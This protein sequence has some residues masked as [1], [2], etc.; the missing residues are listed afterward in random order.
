VPRAGFPSID[1]GQVH[2]HGR[3]DRRTLDLQL[4]GTVRSRTTHISYNDIKCLPSNQLSFFVLKY[5]LK[6]LHVAH[7]SSD[8]VQAEI[9]NDP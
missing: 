4:S 7:Q 2:R 6:F 3:I 5:P 8:E 9:Q 1:S